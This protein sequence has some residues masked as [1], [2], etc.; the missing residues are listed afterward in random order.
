MKKPLLVIGLLIAIV[1][2]CNHGDRTIHKLLSPGKLPAQTFV[3]D[4]TRDTVLRTQKGALIR[5][6]KG[7]L[8]ADNNTVKLEV[9]E[10][11]S[12]ADMVKGGLTTT[13]NGKPLRSG[14]MIY[15]NPVG[16][17]QVTIAQPISIAT[18]TL[19]IDSNMQLFKGDV[20]GDSTINWTDPSPLPENPQLKAIIAGSMIFKDNCASCHSVKKDLTGP[21]LA[22]AMQ[23]L[24][25]VHNGDKKG[26]YAFVRNPAKVM[27]GVK[28]YQ[29]LKTKFGGAMMT[30]FTLSDTA[31]D[32]VFAYIEN[33]A[34][35]M[36]SSTLK[37]GSALSCKDSCALYFQEIM[38]WSEIK[39]DLEKDKPSVEEKREFSNNTTIDTSTYVET[40]DSAN[41]TTIAPADT[42]TTEPIN[43][44]VLETVSPGEHTSLYYQFT[45]ES[46]GWHNIDCLLGEDDDIKNSELK[47]LMQGE[48]KESV[49]LYLIIPAA[50]VF[51]QGGLLK[52]KENEYGF[53]ESNGSIPLP[54][55]AKAYIIA[56]G[57]QDGS[58]IFS[59]KEFI[60]SQ[61]QVIELPLTKITTEALQ[62]E[63]AK[64]EISDLKI[65][66]KEVG[67]GEKKKTQNDLDNAVKELKNAEQLKPK[68]CDCESFLQASIAY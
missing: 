9:K 63:L 23:R 57:E 32:C 27:S 34:N 44:K 48:Y 60:T 15:I 68:N 25:P 39:S 58:A 26:I 41:D 18:P 12:M 2:A 17:D 66:G 45:I 4:I 67:K 6:P 10:A 65:K 35:G 53:Y 13:S 19:F 62:R 8:K 29:D 59:K 64:I 5:I 14:G 30:A 3:I 1:Y 54:Q 21:A 49:T 61:K 55:Q 46:F 52:G 24:L 16:N 43:P 42:F 28:Y 50:K 31:L 33:T 38:K 22:G 56:M 7:A 51:V 40:I 37:T 11:Y 20:Q 36:L 47:V